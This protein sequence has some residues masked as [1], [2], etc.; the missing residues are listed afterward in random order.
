MPSFD[1]VRMANGST[2]KTVLRRKNADGAPLY[3][4]YMRKWFRM[5]RAVILD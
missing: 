3:P 1:A 5:F 4:D 2:A